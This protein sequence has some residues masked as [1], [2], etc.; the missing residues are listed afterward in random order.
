MK[1]ILSV[2]LLIILL[3]CT[4]SVSVSAEDSSQTSFSPTLTSL[5][6]KKA[7]DWLSTS[8]SRALLSVLLSLDLSAADE[9][10]DSSN[11]LSYS[12]YV[13]YDDNSMALCVILFA[14]S[15]M[16]YIVYSPL[17]NLAYYGITKDTVSELVAE[18]TLNSVCTEHYKN[19]REDV[20]TVTKMVLE[21]FGVNQ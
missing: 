9:S 13:G 3:I 20:F 10:F 1:K 11:V 7:S 18:I 14:E 12:S 15:D 16:Y 5:I 21:A 2:F 4:F 8:E 19:T 17:Y 6:E